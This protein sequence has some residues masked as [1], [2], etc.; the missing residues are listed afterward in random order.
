MNLYKLAVILL[1]CLVLASCSRTPLHRS[2]QTRKTTETTQTPTVIQ[3]TDSVSPTD[4]H[5]NAPTDNNTNPTDLNP[6]KT[7]TNAPRKPEKRPAPS[8]PKITFSE[9]ESAHVRVPGNN[10]LPSEGL[11]ILPLAQLSEDFCFPYQGKVISNYGLRGRSMHTGVD[12]KAIPGDTIRAAFPGV[13]RM[14]K[15]YSGYGNIIVIYHYLG[16]E[17]VYAHCQKNLVHAN[18]VVQA[19]TPI[20]LAGRTG[21]ATTEHLHFEVRAANNHF[22][23]GKMLDYENFSLRNDTLYIRQ[24]ADK[25]ILAYNSTA[26][27]QRLITQ[28]SKPKTS[29]TTTSNR[30]SDRSTSS[31]TGSK[32][33]VIRKGDTFSTIAKRFG[34]TVSQLMRLNPNAEPRRL[35]IGQ[36]IKLP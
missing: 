17:T 13:V 32:V 28:A 8:Y 19:G 15:Y 5:P 35:Q 10:P 30:T 23:P 2:K 34:T 25:G 9:E 14:S 21:R 18:D 11:L 20:G 22:N 36:K 16:F 7:D 4:S 24:K 27:G 33:Y 31:N 12:I 6:S 29:S 3:P 26:E 1:G